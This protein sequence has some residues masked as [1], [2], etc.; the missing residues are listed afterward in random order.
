MG[1][2]PVGK[3]EE[4]LEEL[5]LAFPVKLNG[6]ERICTTDDSQQRQHKDARQRMLTRSFDAR[7]RN[8][9]K[10]LKNRLCREFVLHVTCPLASPARN[11]VA[12][13]H[14]ND[15]RSRV[16]SNRS[17]LL[18]VWRDSP[19]PGGGL[20]VEYALMLL[21]QAARTLDAIHRSG[22]VHR[23]LKPE[24][25]VVVLSD[26]H[27]PRLKIVDFGIAKCILIG[28]KPATTLGVGTVQY[29]APE[30]MRGDRDI[31]PAADLYSLA[32]VT[33]ALLTGQPYWVNDDCT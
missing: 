30:Q 21:H 4:R 15:A 13:D 27:E 25:M 31:G 16:S 32:H 8:T 26:S 11:P 17:K 3:V 33:F 28:G 9:L 5:L 22:V 10:V 19:G 24:N 1:R 7:V 20:P 23:D 18:H 12:R 6:H 14:T 29:E 2:N